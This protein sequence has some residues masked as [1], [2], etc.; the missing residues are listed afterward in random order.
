MD[1]EKSLIEEVETEAE[2]IT[3]HERD[4]T[5]EITKLRKS[6]LFRMPIILGAIILY[7]LVLYFGK[8]KDFNPVD[9]PLF[10]ILEFIVIIVCIVLYLFDY[11][12]KK[13]NSRDELTYKRYKILNDTLDFMS[14]VPYLMLFVTMVN[15]L[16]FSFSPISGSS[17]EPNFSDSES[18]IFSHTNDTYERFDVVIVYVPDMTEPYLIKRVIGL[19]G[20]AVIIN[21]GKIYIDN[22]LLEEVYIDQEMV[23]TV[24]TTGADPNYCMWI[25]PEDSYFVMGDNRDGRAVEGQISGSSNDSRSFGPVHVE[26]IMGKVVYKFK[27]NRFFN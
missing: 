15:S 23:S 6:S 9:N 27:E 19:P 7:S 3:D 12:I 16:F 21:Q 22:V 5:D 13:D 8:Y 2:V 4:F 14:V 26:N 17:M 25:V 20:E 24:C 18:V 1:E 10:I 11:N